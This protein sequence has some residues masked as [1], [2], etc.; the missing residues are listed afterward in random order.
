MHGLTQGRGDEEQLKHR[1]LRL[2]KLAREISRMRG[3]EKGRWGIVQAMLE[4]MGKAPSKLGGGDEGERV[5][6]AVLAKVRDGGDLEGDEEGY[7][8]SS[9]E[10]GEI[11]GEMA[12]RGVGEAGD[13]RV[14]NSLWSRLVPR[15]LLGVYRNGVKGRWGGKSGC[16]EHRRLWT[17]AG[18]AAHNHERLEANRAKMFLKWKNSEKCR[19]ILDAT[20]VHRMDP[21]KSPKSQLP[22]LEGLR[23]WFGKCRRSQ[24][25]GG[26]GRVYMAKLD[27]QNV[28]WSIKLPRE[29]QS[30]FM[31]RGRG[32]G[33]TA[34]GGCPLAGPTAQPSMNTCGGLGGKRTRGARAVRSFSTC[35][36]KLFFPLVLF[37]APHHYLPLP[38][39][40]PVCRGCGIGRRTVGA[41]ADTTPQLVCVQEHVHEAWVYPSR[42]L[43]EIAFDG[44]SR[45][46]HSAI[47]QRAQCAL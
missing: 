1:L 3:I 27:L 33:A 47:S 17:H 15:D 23:G 37:S 10:E 41:R 24:G 12:A 39:G 8:S 22:A 26:R 28:F 4:G 45:C 35:V 30:L 42:S 20:P 18:V 34:T 5:L 44:A 13:I 19:A 36:Y 11:T 7:Y 2:Q 21:R 16:T 29:W 46:A 38:C 32:G 6:L 40:E 43:A 14:A 25:R 31:V 9:E